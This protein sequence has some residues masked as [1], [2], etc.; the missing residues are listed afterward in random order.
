MYCTNEKCAESKIM[1][2]ACFTQY[3]ARLVDELAKQGKKW[4]FS[5]M[6]LSKSWLYLR[7]VFL[8][9]FS[10]LFMS[11]NRCRSSS[12]LNQPYTRKI[13]SL[14]GFCLDEPDQLWRVEKENTATSGSGDPGPFFF[15]VIVENMNGQSVA[16]VQQSHH[17]DDD[18][19]IKVNLFRDFTTYLS[20][21]NKV[22]CQLYV[23]FSAREQF[24][25]SNHRRQS[26]IK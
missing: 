4:G 14:E 20:I 5:E 1:H 22:S 24:F 18:K 15:C 2:Q 25:L 19:Q 26:I 12:T 21:R 13:L 3:E 23:H 16:P 9:H 7:M 11:R 17:I 8:E 6:N 10:C